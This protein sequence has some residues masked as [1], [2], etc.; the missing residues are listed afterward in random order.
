MRFAVEARVS[1]PSVDKALRGEEVKGDAGSRIHA[2]L[3]R[4]GLVDPTARDLALDRENERTRAMLAPHIE[5]VRRLLEEHGDE[6]AEIL[7]GRSATA[8]RA[9]VAGEGTL[10]FVLGPISQAASKIDAFLAEAD[11]AKART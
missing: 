2:V 4:A 11:L 3:L 10:A 8:L 9:F 5:R 6:Q 7:I 1:L